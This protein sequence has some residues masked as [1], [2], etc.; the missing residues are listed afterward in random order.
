MDKSTKTILAVAGALLFPWN[1]LFGASASSTLTI[2]DI[3][4]D[5]PKHPTKYYPSR[6]LGQISSVFIHHSATTSGTPYAYAEYHILERDFPGIAYHFVIDKNGKINQTNY[7]DTI[8]YH[9]S[10]KNTASIGICLTG[11]YDIQ[12]PPNAQID[13]C[14]RLITY[15]NG[16]LGRN[17]IIHGHR[18]FANKSCPGDNIDME[19]IKSLVYHNISGVGTNT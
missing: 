13:S 12:S 1:R 9:V 17:L 15:L 3:T 8:S 2:Y 10:G 19:W 4:D 16:I 11:N 18:D 5:L 6:S 14:V 7:L